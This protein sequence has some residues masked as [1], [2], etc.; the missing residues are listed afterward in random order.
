MLLNNKSESDLIQL[1]LLDKS[2][3]EMIQILSDKDN[4]AFYEP[5][6]VKLKDL[7]KNGLKLKVEEKRNL[8]LNILKN[9][10]SEELSEKL[11]DVLFEGDE[12]NIEPIPKKR[13]IVQSITT[14]MQNT[15]STPAIKNEG[16][17]GSCDKV[18][19]DQLKNNVTNMET[20]KG[21][22]EAIVQIG[23]G[24]EDSTSSEDRAS[25]K[26]LDKSKKYNHFFKMT[27][28]I[29][30]FKLNRPTNITSEDWM[31]R[32]FDSLIEEIRKESMSNADKVI[33]RVII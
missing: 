17:E 8:L 33:L 11:C 20:D 5:I 24:S 31:Q 32:G 16:V 30:N 25:L 9:L 26:I 15:G 1:I 3:D 27:Q 21:E 7:L 2:V 19:E 13:K 22:N 10:M 12:D 4:S 6:M 28:M 14:V 18:K 23:G 29:I